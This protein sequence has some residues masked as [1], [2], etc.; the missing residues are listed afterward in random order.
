MPNAI[1]GLDHVIVAVRDIAAA[2]ETFHRLGFTLWAADGDDRRRI[3]LADGG[4]ELR[5]RPEA[6]E[7]LMALAFGS[8]DLAADGRRL[9]PEM[10]LGAAV[11]LCPPSPRQPEG[12]EHAN[13]ATGIASVTALVA[14]PVGLMTAWDHLIG[15][16]AATATD[17]TVTIHGN[18][19]HSG[20]GLV[21]LCRPMDLDQLH[22]EA[23]DGTPTPPPAL[24]A[25]TVT[26]AS[27]ATAARVL[28]SN[29]V[30]YGRDAGGTLR[31]AAADACGVFMEM[32]E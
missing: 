26:V 9:S 6:R 12:A 28:R 19:S 13:T 20:R 1:T 29:G 32:V 17:E 16:A 24:V 4:L 5:A 2:A 3:A 31:I 23:E 25:L 15:P 11:L 7:G 10:A 14:D 21:F 27:T 30:A 22:P 8:I 18:R